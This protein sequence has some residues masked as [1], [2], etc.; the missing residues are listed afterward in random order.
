VVEPGDADGLARA[1]RDLAS[2]PARVGEM[3]RRAFEAYRAK[4]TVDEATRTFERLWGLA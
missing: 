2:D 4:Y 3:G 1:V